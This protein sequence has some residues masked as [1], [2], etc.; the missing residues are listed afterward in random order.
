MQE[1]KDVTIYDIAEKLD[2]SPATVSRGLKDHPAIKKETKKR[3]KEMAAKMGYQNNTFASNLRSRKTNTIGIIIPR[4]NSN[5]MSSVISGVE[6]VVNSKGYNLI[7]SQTQEDYDKEIASATT[8]FNSRVDGLLVSLAS[9]TDRIVHFES[10]LRKKIPVIFF[11]RVLPHPD[12]TNVVIDNVQAGYDAVTHLIDQGCR[13]IMYVGG[14]LK[15]NVYADRLKGYKLALADKDI[16]FTD[17]Y[18]HTDVLSE[19]TGVDAAKKLLEMKPRPDGVFAANDSSAVA[20]MQTLQ[21]AGVRIPEDVAVVGFNNDPISW[22]ARPKL[23]TVNY[24][25]YE[26]GQIAATTLINAI[27]KAPSSSLTTLVLK[28]ELIVRDS[29]IRDKVNSQR[30]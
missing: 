10:L 5:F 18:V 6:H 26:M 14:S 11:D 9:N 17:K 15:R 21:D 4:I 12:C 30:A 13:R 25:G 3:I 22:I 27:N 23:T 16:S 28:H 29:S 20:C 8:M 7:I 1:H 24:P 19:H 2:I